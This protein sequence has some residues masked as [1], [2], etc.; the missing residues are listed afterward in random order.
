M[1][2]KSHRRVS[3]NS[4]GDASGNNHHHVVVPAAAPSTDAPV[5]P[6]GITFDFEL[7]HSN[8]ELSSPLFSPISPGST[9]ALPANEGQTTPNG[10]APATSATAKRAHG[11]LQLLPHIP[12]TAVRSNSNS[13]RRIMAGESQETGWNAGDSL[14]RGGGGNGGGGVADSGSGAVAAPM[15]TRSKSK[16]LSSHF[17]L[18]LDL[19][20]PQRVPLSGTHNDRPRTAH[21]SPSTPR[22]E[23]SL[24]PK[25]SD[26]PVMPPT[27]SPTLP[28]MNRSFI[29]SRDKPYN[30]APKPF[31]TLQGNHSSPDLLSSH[32]KTPV[33]R[34]RGPTP[35]YSN[36]AMS[37]QASLQDLTQRSNYSGSTARPSTHASSRTATSTAAPITTIGTPYGATA[38]SFPL[39]Q[40]VKTRPKTLGVTSSVAGVTVP[41]HHTSGIKPSPKQS[42]KSEARKSEVPKK[43]GRLLNPMFLLQRRRSSQDP[44]A[45]EA[46][47]ANREAQAKAVARQKDVLASGVN[48]PP[49]DFDPRIKGKLV[50]DFSAPREKRN[51]FGESDMPPSPNLR[52]SQ[53]SSDPPMSPSFPPRHASLVN[54]TPRD[55]TRRSTH[56]PIFRENL[57]EDPETSKRLSSIHAEN[58]EN[59]DFLQRASKQSDA[60][61]RSQES[62]VLPPF[63][64]RSQML[65]PMQ[66]SLFHDDESKRSS[67]PSSPIARDSSPSEVDQVSPATARSSGNDA[68][69]PISVDA[70]SPLGSRPVSHLNTKLAQDQLPKSDSSGGGG[71]AFGSHRGSTSRPYSVVLAPPQIDTI[72]EGSNDNSPIET[73]HSRAEN[74]EPRYLARGLSIRST[75]SPGAPERLEAPSTPGVTSGQRRAGSPPDM[76]AGLPTPD[77]TPKSVSDVSPKLVEKRKSAA[78]HSRKVSA[79]PKKH[80][81]NASRFSFQFGGESAAQEQALEE[82]HR[83][84]ASREITEPV[85]RSAGSGE[86]EDD[87]DYFD[88]D[89]M[90]DMDELE[91]QVPSEDEPQ[92]MLYPLSKPGDGS[93]SNAGT[94][95]SSLYLQ[96]A[97]E[98]LRQPDSDDGSLYDDDEIPQVTDEH[99]LTYADH[100]A[101]RAHSAMGT[102]SR[103]HSM[104]T[105]THDGYWRDSTIDSYMRDSYYPSTGQ[106]RASR[107]TLSTSPG[108]PGGYAQDYLSAIDRDSQRFSR[109]QSTLHVPGQPSR[110]ISSAS[111][112]RP[113]LPHRDSGNSERNRAVSG[114]SFSTPGATPSSERVDPLGDNRHQ[115]RAVSGLSEATIS[116]KMSHPHSHTN[117]QSVSASAGTQSQATG[118]NAPLPGAVDMSS[119]RS[120]DAHTR[121]RTRESDRTS[122]DSGGSS[123]NVASSP[124]S[125]KEH[126][127][128]LSVRAPSRNAPS[129]QSANS[130]LSFDDFGRSGFARGASPITPRDGQFD[131]IGLVSTPP[132][133]DKSDEDSQLAATS[134]DTSST[135]A[136]F[137][138]GLGLSSFADFDFGQQFASMTTGTTIVDASDSEDEAE[139]APNDRHSAA[140]LAKGSEVAEDA[141]E[142]S[143]GIHSIPMHTA[144]SPSGLKSGFEPSQR[145]AV[146]T[147]SPANTA[148]TSPTS[149]WMNSPQFMQHRFGS[150]PL[151]NSP[152]HG[153]QRFATLS[154]PATTSKS[155]TMP[156]AGRNASNHFPA[157]TSPK[158][159][160][161]GK[162]AAYDDSQDDM[163]FDDGN[164]GVDFGE[165]IPTAGGFDENAFDDDSFLYRPN[166]A[167]NAPHGYGHRQQRSDLSYETIGS[168]GPYPSFAV[169]NASKA[170]ARN[171]QMML[172]DLPVQAPV[173][174]KYI[175]Q[176]NPSEDARRLGLS[177]KAPPAPVSDHEPEAFI[178]MQDSLQKYHA[179]LAEAANRA[180]SE[181]RFVRQP[182]SASTIAST[183]QKPESAVPQLAV[184]TR[185]GRDDLSMYSQ[186]ED[187]GD[188]SMSYDNENRGLNRNDFQASQLSDAVGYSPSKMTFDFGFDQPT[189]SDMD[190]YD[191]DDLVA[192]ANAEV[193]ASD[194]EG[195]YGQEFDFYGRPRAGSNDLQAMNGGYWGP[196]GDDGLQ[197]NK[198]L[199]EPNLTPIT[200]RSEF[201]TRNSFVAGMPGFGLPAANGF[202]SHSPALSRMPITPLMENDITSFDELRR[203]RAQAFG[204]SNRSEK[205]SSNRSS[206]QSFGMLSPTIDTNVGGGASHGQYGSSPMQ[207]GYSNGSSGSSNQSSAKPL[208]MDAGFH[209]HD[210][211]QSATSSNG[212][213][214]A[215]DIDS[216]PKRN[217][218][219]FTEPVTAKKAPPRMMSPTS[220]KSSHSRNGSGADSIN[221]VQ[222]PDPEGSGRPRWVLERR[223]TSEQGQIELVG[224]ELVQGGWI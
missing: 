38:D 129:Q 60:T 224:R 212:N 222:E 57:D 21:G 172:E 107:M 117:S 96:Q 165:A 118:G 6:M 48:I 130:G 67:D 104:M 63:A 138:A 34:S 8:S 204:G 113:A 183:A 214:F 59:K 188:N 139:Y 83:K 18:D 28:S 146:S 5:S 39:P 182:S 193:L 173:D 151:P 43:K 46:E 54:R 14:G 169:P 216:T 71:S 92:S 144:T 109:P 180:A 32:G 19:A 42:A 215:L 221:Y 27:P 202:G 41:T 26:T 31:A 66:A 45:V 207:Y 124:P 110:P 145:A 181:G 4:F 82:K 1:F 210:S 78:G 55:G 112:H 128:R 190:D 174:P 101:F 200:E 79:I 211:P 11:G 97:R 58:L 164:F 29:D 154:S 77:Q 179:A 20:L 186:H 100:P 106:T 99:D 122:E 143:K 103:H 3:N 105:D 152:Q 223:R 126:A 37:P 56:I 150:P 208:P 50:H 166:A 155:P 49:P 88:E 98:A 7:P 197:R 74:Q 131:N 177:D 75:P 127:N 23:A 185:S 115:S 10:G 69:S 30:Q 184:D 175:P 68:I 213:S 158:T 70:T 16:R 209:F 73:L 141:G 9:S 198:S 84:I 81:S 121:D 120:R 137:S 25:R 135:S 80:A 176:R 62:A 206:Q 119:S 205:S 125:V 189:I 13:A 136:P 163:Y 218:N 93:I 36:R 87:D 15:L 64:R 22:M 157:K 147:A 24:F 217:T 196:D 161:H 116:D 140:G 114:F 187:G 167:V 171:S 108:Q 159:G 91:M 123:T 89:A 191:D 132:V 219:S 192:A 90:D 52:E 168:D 194:D 72:A 102:N 220:P 156:S 195:F 201:S 33:S 40:H 199:R 134:L 178:H 51:T 153:Q 47:R 203:L 12:P 170:L 76:T 85:I 44:D 35:I 95:Q 53:T 61:A 94:S 2:G 162:R 133:L 160:T 111:P 142:S 149:A 65:D 148:H 86:E 17:E